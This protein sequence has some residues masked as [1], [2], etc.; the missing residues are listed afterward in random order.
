MFWP[1]NWLTEQWMQENDNKKDFSGYSNYLVDFGNNFI[2]TFGLGLW[3]K[4]SRYQGVGKE[5]FDAVKKEIQERLDK[6]FPLVG[7]IKLNEKMTEDSRLFSI[8]L[9][10]ISAELDR[11][12][13]VSS[14]LYRR[15]N[16]GWGKYIGAFF[17]RRDF[18]LEIKWNEVRLNEEI[19]RV[20]SQ[21]ERPFVPSELI[22][23]KGEVRVKDGQ[24]G[25]KVDENWLKSEMLK[26]IREN[27][28]DIRVEIPVE[29]VGTLPDLPKKTEAIKKAKTLLDKKMILTWET[30]K[31]EVD[32][33]TSL[34]W[35]DFEENCNKER[36]F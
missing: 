32:K 8:E 28:T 13:M 36:I 11:E 30:E 6:D 26:T 14:L 3:E 1:M 19:D 21:I 31:S 2:I 29:V 17:Q 25:K 16:Q 12:K 33:T 24:T 22:T 35:I 15:L 34:N 23:E 18:E 10:S 5:L 4:W 9:S 7:I 27:K 20:V